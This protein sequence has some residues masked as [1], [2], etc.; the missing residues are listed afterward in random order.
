MYHNQDNMIELHDDVV[1]VE[2]ARLQ[3]SDGQPVRLHV[4]Y[5]LRP[6][7][8]YIADK[9]ADVR[10]HST[11]GVNHRWM[12]LNSPD[13]ALEAYLAPQTGKVSDAQG[14]QPVV[15]GENRALFFDDLG[16]P[17]VSTEPMLDPND[18]LGSPDSAYETRRPYGDNLAYVE[19]EFADGLSEPERQLRRQQALVDATT[20]KKRREGSGPGNAN[21]LRE[22]EAKAEEK[23]QEDKAQAAQNR[24]K[25][26]GKET[27]EEKKDK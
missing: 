23:K 25:H 2:K 22:D 20:A 26:E 19:G 15:D 7:R 24:D 18:A 10:L 1:G 17:K 5:I 21:S 4:T 11:N 13:P 6:D 8:H 27:K 9:N 12:P 3:V 14:V 16:N